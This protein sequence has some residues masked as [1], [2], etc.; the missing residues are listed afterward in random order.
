MDFLL[1]L[2]KGLTHTALVAIG[3]GTEPGYIWKDIPFIEFLAY[4]YTSDN[5]HV[6]GANLGGPILP[7][8]IL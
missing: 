8:N 4:S 1:V 7:P 6:E 5:S 2:K 3:H